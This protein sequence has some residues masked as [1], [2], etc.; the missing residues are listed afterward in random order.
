MIEW[1][2]QGAILAVRPH[3]E[4]SA[5]IEVFTR[6][7]GR[8]AG[9]VRGGLS[10][11]R[12]GQLQPGAQVAV[13]WRARL[14]SHLGAFAVEPV[15]SRAAQ[16]MGDRLSLAGLS[17]V[18]ALL[19]AALPERDPHPL[20]YDRTI[21][22]LDLLGQTAVWPLAYLQWEL[23]LLEELG[24]GLDLTACAVTGRAEDLAYV[25][26]RSGRA[27]SRAAAGAWADRLL[28]L[29]PVLRGAGEAGDAEVAA[30]LGTTGW[31]IE[32]RLLPGLGD[33]PMP[34]A[35]GRLVALLAARA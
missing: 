2:D 24:F 15:R 6:S 17:S 22:L 16:A 25:S 30:A 9:I 21:L 31:F 1:E 8:H 23:A 34:A 18:T 5:I 11:R 10:R 33:R 27:V 19:S 28:P 12:A 32:H 14:E 3:G 29:P 7:H 26:P 13:V 20:F 35:R 4:G